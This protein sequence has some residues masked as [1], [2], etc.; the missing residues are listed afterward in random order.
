MRNDPSTT[1]D[2]TGMGI[3]VEQRAGMYTKVSLDALTVRNNAWVLPSAGYN[4]NYQ[5]NN[6][7]WKTPSQ[8]TALVP[9]DTFY[10]SY[11]K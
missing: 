9:S 1:R 2:A 11:G 4:G 3:G 10:D 6:W 5:Y 8:W 7:S